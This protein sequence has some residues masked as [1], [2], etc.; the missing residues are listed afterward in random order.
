MK[1]FLLTTILIILALTSAGSKGFCGGIDYQRVYRELEMPTFSYVHNI[2][3]DQYYD[4]KGFSWSPYPLFRLNS[5]LFFKNIT[6]APGYYS[7]TPREYEGN[8][9]ILFKESGLVKYIVPVFN[10]DF[11]PEYFYETHLPKPR[12]T[13]GQK[14][15]QNI[16]N[17]IGK[18]AKQSS[19]KQFP[20]SYLEVTDLDNN[21]VVIVIYYKEF[22]YSII[23]RTV[24]M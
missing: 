11:V 18:H 5:A 1:R 23:M 19:K 15:K 13:F 12:L 10:K 22:K 20:Q 24:K 17:F 9:Y 8:W 2:D 7:L 4:C 16:F 21:F 6:I 3:P 14:V